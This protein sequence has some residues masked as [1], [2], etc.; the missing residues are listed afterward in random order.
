MT[1]ICLCGATGHVGR[2]LAAAIDS[3]PDLTLTAAVGAST[4]GQ[5]LP[6]VLGAA[7]PDVPIF[8]SVAEAHAKTAFDVVIDYTTPTAVYDNVTAAIRR[9]VHCVIGTS[10]LT[11]EQYTDIHRLAEEHKTGVLAAG[12][13][14]ITAALMQHFAV[15]AARHIPQWEIVDYGSDTKVDAPSGTSRE[16]AFKLSQVGSPAYTIDPKTRWGLP[17]AGARISTAP[18]YTACGCPASIPLRK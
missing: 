5:R 17:T 14:S 15:L 9:Q 16:L 10:G 11:D 3:A 18:R 12:N 13:F 7:Y 4:A 8:A 2:E 1:T 6:E